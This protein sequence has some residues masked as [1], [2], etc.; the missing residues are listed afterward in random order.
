M[1]FVRYT[2]K[3]TLATGHV[4]DTDYEIEFGIR[5]SYRS[6]APDLTVQKS[7]SG[8]RESLYYGAD[9]IYDVET[10]LIAEADL[11]FWREF[12]DSVEGGAE[13]QYDSDGTVA[14]PVNLLNG[15]LSRGSVVREIRVEPEY[16]RF[17]FRFERRLN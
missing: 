13:F 14:V 17:A 1:A 3:R 15:Y 6:R 8:D 2:A 16:Y 4:V 10:Q 11:E 7:L 9:E 5:K 12:A